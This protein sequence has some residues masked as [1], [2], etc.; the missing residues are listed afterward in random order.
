M[1]RMESA[2]MG[3]PRIEIDLAA[4]EQKAAEGLNDVE[5]AAALGISLSTLMRRK[6]SFDSFDQAYKR[7]KAK[8]D[9]EVSSQLF[10]LVK[11]KNLGAIVWYEKTRKGYTDKLDVGTRDVDAAIERE[12]A[13]L[14]GARKVANAEALADPE[15][16]SGAESAIGDPDPAN[17]AA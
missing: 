14:A 5:L 10:A 17:P 9:A 3:R 4:V 2:A 15:R 8:A 11:E 1:G 6:R 13:K 7:G 12:L 16:S